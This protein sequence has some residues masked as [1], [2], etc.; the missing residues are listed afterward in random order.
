MKT[1]KIAIITGGVLNLVLALFHIV[2]CRMIYADCHTADFYPMMQMFAVSGAAL[3]WFLA[4]TSLLFR[5]QLALTAVGRSIL[6]LNVVIYAGRVISELA[7]FPASFPHPKAI[8]IASCSLIAALYVWI[9]IKGKSQS[10][11]T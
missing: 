9:F 1:L 5:E 10:L 11:K 4:L 7:L 8:I 2:L 6:L 3:I